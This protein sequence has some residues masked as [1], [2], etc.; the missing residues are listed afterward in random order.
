MNYFKPNAF[1][2]SFQQIDIMSLK[3]SGIKLLVCDLD[4]TLAPHFNKF[5]INDA[6]NFCQE[7]KKNG[8]IFVLASNNFK[9]RV[10]AFAD[11]INPDVVIWNCKKPLKHK[12]KKNIKKFNVKPSE[13]VFIGDQFLIDVFCANRFGAKS[14][15]VFPL[16]NVKYQT[17]KGRLSSFIEKAIYKKISLQNM[18]TGSLDN[19]SLDSC[20]II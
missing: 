12:I 17:Q 11:K 14:I 7:I 13:I 6:I 2:P 9:K 1:V 3:K 4:N 8:I 16:T 15:L 5:P 20:D 18:N 10:K 19:E